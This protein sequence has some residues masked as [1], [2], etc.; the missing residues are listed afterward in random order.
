MPEWSTVGPVLGGLA[1]VLTALASLWGWQE[2]KR[3]LKADA[4][5]GEAQ[6]RREAAGASTAEVQ[7]S[8][9]SVDVGIELVDKAGKMALGQAGLLEGL[10]TRVDGLMRDRDKTDKILEDL[11]R[12]EHRCQEDLA[13]VRQRLRALE[14]AAVAPSAPPQAEPPT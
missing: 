6:A 12:T 7:A 8:S 13:E 1:A 5:L 3:R 2:R 11:A 9:A 14:G 4:S 10:F